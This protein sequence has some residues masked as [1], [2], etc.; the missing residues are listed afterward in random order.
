MINLL[1]DEQKHDIRAARTNVILLRYNFIT[2]LA[3]GLLLAFCWL[4][5]VLLQ[6][7]QQRALALSNDNGQK[8]ATLS[9]VRKEADTYRQNLTTANQILSGSTGYT[10]MIVAIT[11][12][13][14]KGV[15]LDTLSLS[16]TSLTQPTQFQ[17]HATSYDTAEQLKQN[18]QSSELFKNV[19]FVSLTAA[20]QST[21]SPTKY[22]VSLTLSAQLDPKG[23]TQ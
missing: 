2:L 11:K 14:P 16:T 13:L 15:V 21:G 7:N 3:I 12:L 5:Y 9:N 17:A 20:D 1:P 6:A 23:L 10:D 18:F 8:A 22:P 4:F 19:Y